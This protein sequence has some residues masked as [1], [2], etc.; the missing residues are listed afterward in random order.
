MSLMAWAFL[1]LI[2]LVA[3]AVVCGKK[4][5]QGLL[6]VMAG[7]TVSALMMAVLSAVAF[8]EEAA[9]LTAAA[10]SYTN[11]LPRGR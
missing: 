4:A 6:V 2:T 1:F 7:L 8:A 5:A 9:G 11:V 10:E 3:V